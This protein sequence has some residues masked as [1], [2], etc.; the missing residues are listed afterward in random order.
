MHYFI[1]L[2]LIVNQLPALKLQIKN[3][4][5]NISNLALQN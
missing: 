5:K 3:D 1:E 4:N 2:Q